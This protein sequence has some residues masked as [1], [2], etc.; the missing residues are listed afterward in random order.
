MIGSEQPIGFDLKAIARRLNEP[1]IR[2]YFETIGMN[3]DAVEVGLRRKSEIVTEWTPADA[4]S[5][6][7][8]SDLFPKN[9]FYF[10]Y[11]TNPPHGVVIPRAR[12]RSLRCYGAP[13][14]TPVLG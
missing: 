4:R 12:P 7:V 10:P 1:A 5:A 13:A 9:E 2:A 3:T 11:T 8:V 6:D 14:R